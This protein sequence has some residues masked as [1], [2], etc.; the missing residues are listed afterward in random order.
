[1][2]FERVLCNV[3]QFSSCYAVSVE[4]GPMHEFGITGSHF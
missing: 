4:F 3:V 1:M 2:V